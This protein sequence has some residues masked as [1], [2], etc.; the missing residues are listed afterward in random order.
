M[1]YPNGPGAPAQSLPPK[2]GQAIIMDGGRMLHG[3]ERTHPGFLNGHLRKGAFNRIEHQGN[4]TW[5]MMSNEDIVQ[6]FKTDDF[7]MTFVWRG[8]C[9]RDEEERAKFELQLENEEYTDLS[10]ILKKLELDMHKNGK[11]SPGKG[12]ATMGPKNFGK[13]LLQTYMQY[14]LDAPGAWIPINYCAAGHGKPWLTWLLSPFCTDI[15]PRNPQNDKHPPPMRF[16]DPQNRT[17]RMT[18]CPNGFQGEM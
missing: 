9:F 7:R 16:C 5:Y 2:R 17:R 12:L 13:L 4:D 14:P 6:V 18:N 8:L 11:L 1:F 10:I 3:V 15:S